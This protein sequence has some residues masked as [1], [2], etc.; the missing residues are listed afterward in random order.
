MMPS[1]DFREL[2][3]GEFQASFVQCSG[4][5]LLLSILGDTTFLSA[6]DASMK[7]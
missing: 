4:L 5:K 1:A 7:R 6:A 2:E 3:S